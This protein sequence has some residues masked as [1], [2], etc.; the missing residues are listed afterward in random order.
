MVETFAPER[1]HIFKGTEMWTFLWHWSAE[2]RI[3]RFSARS[4]V[5]MS[6]RADDHWN[7]DASSVTSNSNALFCSYLFRFGGPSFRQSNFGE[8]NVYSRSAPIRPFIIGNE[9]RP[10]PDG[11]ERSPSRMRWF[12]H[13]FQTFQWYWDRRSFFRKKYTFLGHLYRLWKVFTSWRFQKGRHR[14][15]VGFH[16]VFRHLSVFL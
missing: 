16:S 13:R 10:P 11:L 7:R 2:H 14:E 12:S 5:D 4:P 1:S 9:N 3:A 15:F 6:L 8:I